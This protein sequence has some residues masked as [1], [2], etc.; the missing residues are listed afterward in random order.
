MAVQNKQRSHVVRTFDWRGNLL[1]YPS[2][3][4]N[5]RVVID[6]HDVIHRINNWTYVVFWN[7]N[8]F[9]KLVISWEIAAFE[10]INNE[11][12]SVDAKTCISHRTVLIICIQLFL[13]FLHIV[14]DIG[15]RFSTDDI[16][17][18][19]TLKPIVA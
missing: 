8:P 10:I 1:A 19:C 13:S 11:C 16:I 5:P 2:V 14:D 7:I 18:T 12:R 4:T 6:E 15:D 9:W 3:S 17:S